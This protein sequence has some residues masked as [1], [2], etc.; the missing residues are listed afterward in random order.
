MAAGGGAGAGGTQRG[1]RGRK[2]D[3]SKERARL[4]A[5]A[6]RMNEEGMAL[7]QQGKP[8][9][10][11]QRFEVALALCASSTP[12]NSSRT[13]IPTLPPAST[14]WGVCCS[15]W[16]GWR[17]LEHFQQ[18]LAMY[19]KLYPADKFPDGHPELATSLNNMGT[20]LQFL[21]RLEGALEHFQQGLVMYRKLYP[22]DKFPD[23]HTDLARS[24]NNIGG[25]LQP[26]DRLEGGAEH[27][28]QALAMYRKLYPAD[29]FPD[30][31]RELAH[32]LNNMGFL[33]WSLG[34]LEGALEHYQQGGHVP[35]ALPGRQVLRR[36]PRIGHQ[37]Q[38]HGDCAAVPGSAGG[39]LE[40][41]SRP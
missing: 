29:R 15:H 37:P 14:T 9:Q 27:G 33:L 40:H 7:Y 18:A 13:A 22:A 3:D 35:Q 10:G 41:S 11:L 17:A 34:R 28:Q 26:L 4:E 25:V 19:R 1:K 36:P 23:G 31:H 5:E 32:S 39:A 8:L 21:G 38:Q 16:G 30:G 6:A 12:K 24:L 2:G 20:V